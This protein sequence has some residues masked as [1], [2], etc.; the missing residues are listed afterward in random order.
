MK[1]APTLLKTEVCVLIAFGSFGDVIFAENNVLRYCTTR[2]MKEIS[3]PYSLGEY[4]QYSLRI[5][6]IINVL[7]DF[8]IGIGQK[9]KKRRRKK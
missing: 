2:E 7:K 1:L 9:N 3:A 5:N 8:K 4:F 6:L